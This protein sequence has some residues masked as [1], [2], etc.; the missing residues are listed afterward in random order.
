M[1]NRGLR[2]RSRVPTRLAVGMLLSV[3]VAVGVALVTGVVPPP[4]PAAI[5]P[6]PSQPTAPPSSPRTF[7][8]RRNRQHSGPQLVESYG[9]IPLHF[10]RNEG[11]TDERVA[12]LARGAA[13]TLFLTHAGEAV[14]ALRKGEPAPAVHRSLRHEGR[15]VVSEVPA[16]TTSVLRIKLEGADLRTSAQGRDDLPGKSNY[17]IGSDPRRWR[18]D[19]P[20]FARVHYDHVYP[21]IDLT[22]YGNQRQ[23]EYDWIVSPGADP[24]A[25]GMTFEGALNLSIDAGG[26]LVLALPGGEVVNKPPVVYQDVQGRRVPVPGR[27]VRRGEREIGFDVGAYDRSRPL[28]IDPV[29]VYSTYLG[30]SQTDFGAAIAVG[31]DGSTYLGGLTRS[32]DFPPGT[33]YQPA[34]AGGEDAFL[35]KLNPSGSA[36]VYSTYLGGSGDD[37]AW[38]IAVDAAG[39]AYVSGQTRSTNFPTS[40]PIQPAHAGGLDAFVAKVSASGSVLLYST[41]LG[42]SVDDFGNGIAVDGS[43]SAFVAGSTKSLNFPVASAYQSTILGGNAAFVAKL[44]PSGTT[45]DYSTYLGGVTLAGNGGAEVRSIAVDN[46]GNAYLTGSAFGTLPIAN[47]Y[48]STCSGACAFVTKLGPSGL[49]LD[50]STYLSAQSTGHGIA[51]DGT[52]SAYVTGTTSSQT[53]P[54]VNALQS[55]YA[56]GPFDAFVTR[57]NPIGSTLVYSTYLGGSGDDQAYSVAVDGAGNAYVTGGTLSADFPTVNAYQGYGGSYDVIVTKLSAQGSMIY[58]TYLGGAGGDSGQAIALDLSGSAYV[59]GNASGGFPMVDAYQASFSGGSYDGFVAKLQDRPRLSVADVAETEGTSGIVSATFSVTLSAAPPQQVQVAYETA[60]GTAVAGSDYVATSGVL[61]FSVGVSTQTL[62]VSVLGDTLLEGD[63]FFTLNLSDPVNADIES[64]TATGVVIG[65]DEPLPSIAI[66]DA[67]L[68]EGD[69]GSTSALV[70]LSLSTVRGVPVTAT[71]STA[72]GTAGAESDYDSTSGTVTFAP[73]TTTATILVPVRGDTEREARETFLV[74]LSNSNAYATIDDSTAVVTINDDDSPLATT[75]SLIANR[76]QHTATLLPNGNV[77]V[78]GGG[79]A[80]RFDRSG[81]WSA[82]TAP[83]LYR[84]RHTA[85]MMPSGKALITGGWWFQALGTVQVYDPATGAW[86]NTQSLAAPRADHTTTLLADG[87]VLAVGGTQ[88]AGAVG[89]AEVYDHGS[90]SWSPAGSLITARS[91]HTATLLGDGRVV[92][93]GGFGSSGALGSVE[94]YD[95]TWSAGPSLTTERSGH[96]AVLLGNGKVLVVGGDGASGPLASAQ[97][98]DPVAGTW[99][100]TGPLASPRRGLS[101]ALLNTGEVL[102]AGGTTTGGGAVLD[103]ELYDPDNG[104]WSRAGRLAIQRVSATATVLPTGRVLLVG[105]NPT[106]GHT[107]ELF[108]P[109]TSGWESAGDLGA[110]RSNHTATLLPDGNVLAVGRASGAERFDPGNSNWSA[111]SPPASTRRAHTATLLPSG[112]VLIAGGS[113]SGPPVASSELYQPTTNSW[114][115]TG[116]LVLS[117]SSHT[118][119]LLADG[120]VLAAGGHAFAEAPMASAEL[121]SG[122]TWVQTGSMSVPRF[123]HTATLLRSGRVLVVGG[124][125]GG[126]SLRSAELFDPDTGA[127]MAAAPPNAPRHGHVAALLADGRVLVAGGLAAAGKVEIY[128]P[129]ANSWTSL[130]DQAIAR[131]GATATVLWSGQ[132]AVAGGFDGSTWPARVD[133]FD[134]GTA[135]WVTAALAGSGRRW[136]TATLLPNGQILIA[137]GEVNGGY[138]TSSA[139]FDPGPRGSRVKPAITSMPAYLAYDALA[140]EIAGTDL[141]GDSEAVSGGTSSSSVKYPLIELRSLENGRQSTVPWDSRVTL[142]DE[143]MTLSS[144]VLPEGLDAGPHLVRVVSAGMPSTAR[145]VGV[146]CSVEIVQPPASATVA[147]GQPALFQVSAEG[148][149]RYQWQKNGTSI[150]GAT[151]SSYATPPVSAADAGSTYRVLVSGNCATAI[152]APATLFVTD[153]SGPT[154]AVHS[155]TAG[156]RLPVESQ[157]QVLWTATDNVRVCKATA[158]LEYSNNGG[159]AWSPAPPGG[160]LPFTVDHTSS[161]LAPG[162]GPA[163]SQISYTV[164]TAFPSGHAGSL[165]RVRVQA[166]DLNGNPSDVAASGTFYIVK[167]DPEAQTL[168]LWNRARMQ[169]QVGSSVPELDDLALQL[170]NLADHERVRGVVEDVGSLGPLTSLYAKWDAAHA[171]DTADQ[172]DWANTILFGC[173]RASASES[174]PSWCTPDVQDIEGLQ[175]LVTARKRTLYANLKYVIVVGDDRIIPF[176]RLQDQTSGNASE[177]R[178]VAGG[179]P[180]LTTATTVGRALGANR[181]LSDDPLLTD[182]V[183]RPD[184]VSGLF[185]P[186]FSGGRLVENADEIIKTISTFMGQDGVMDLTA[187]PEGHRVLVTGYDFMLAGASGIRSSWESVPGVG[188]VGQNLLGESWGETLLRQGLQGDG[189]GRYGVMSLNG[190]ATHFLEGVPAAGAVFGLNA[191]DMYGAD[192]CSTTSGNPLNANFDGAVVYSMGCHGGLVVP[193]SC[194]TTNDHTLDLPQTFL[195]RGAAVYL[196]NTGYGYGD[197]GVVAYSMLLSDLFTQ[198]LVGEQSIAVGDAVRMTKS[199]SYLRDRGGI[200]DPTRPGRISGLDAYD[201]KVLMQWTLF[202]MPM[203]ELRLRTGTDPGDAGMGSSKAR[204]RGSSTERIGKVSVNRRVDRGPDAVVE[205][206]LATPGPAVAGGPPQYVTRLSLL[207]DLS[208]TDV[209]TKWHGGEKL[210]TL[211]TPCPEESDPRRQGC[212]Y[213]L[214]NKMST[215]SGMPVQPLMV[216]D[217][218]LSGTSQHG[219]VWMGGTYV[220]EANWT[221]V[222]GGVVTNGFDNSEPLPAPRYVMGE[223]IAT[224]T[225][226]SQGGCRA[227]DDEVNS[228]AITTGE[229]LKDSNHEF[230]I[231]RRYV[232]FD[233]EVLYYNNTNPA[234]AS[235]NCLRTGPALTEG[236]GLFTG[237][238]YHNVTGQTVEWAV[239][240]LP[241]DVWRVVVVYNDEANSVWEPLELVKD[242]GGVWRGSKT[243]T[244]ATRV[245]YL[246]QAVDNRGNVGR[247]LFRDTLP[248]SG[249]ERQFP[250]VVDAALNASPPTPTLSITDVSMAEGNAGTTNAVFTVSLSAASAEIVTVSAVTSDLSANAGSDYTA[251][252]PTT[253]TFA[254]GVT[255]QTFTVPVLGDTTAESTET[256]QVTLSGPMNATIID[257]VGVGTITNDDTAPPARTFVSVLG[258][259]ANVCS[260]QTTPCRN[261]AAA[262]AQVATDGDVIVLNSGDYADAPITIGKGVKV[263]SPS[264]TVA[265]VRQPISVNASSGRVVL[266]GLTI[267][268]LGAGDGVT[269]VAANALSIEDTTIDLWAAGLRL[270]NVAASHVTIVNT[271]FRAS[272]TGITDSGGAV[273]NRVSVEETRF[274]GNTKGIEV[275]AGSFIIRESTFV[276]NSG[277]GVIVGPGS[278]D[279][280]RSE[281]SLNGTGVGALVGGTARI[282]RSR[283]FGNATGLSAAAGG[284][285]TT[286]GR[287]LIRRNGVNVFGAVLTAPEQ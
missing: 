194:S 46:A 56:G 77:L 122:A 115:T 192:R 134:P 69:S 159:A 146:A 256:F 238:A 190:H 24:G 121:Y 54:V 277:N 150:A 203:Y 140:L 67:V 102:V 151:Q 207:F 127:W 2:V 246:L 21:G 209:Y 258:N 253:I 225:G 223:P 38:G 230:T 213:R 175:D 160:G 262:I 167:P 241:A 162:L 7:A 136:H 83:G 276:G 263:S 66:G 125:D 139:L 255:T 109:M 141:R 101:C 184:D 13:Y 108:D 180:D 30:G 252:G 274:E 41:F 261:L 35:A 132:V 110:A 82:V 171:G 148:A 166:W 152:S 131:E 236:G 32:I 18:T 188:P 221:P 218:R 74:N 284:T 72:D 128:D 143:P 199:D 251:T 181:F 26:S 254:P 59:T 48:R 16:G 211:T 47:A 129:D 96:C 183:I 62:T 95:G 178:Y 208:A 103:T 234:Q 34:N 219:V 130:P 51:V 9:Q 37:N 259:D 86:G 113:V 245:G 215:G 214:N 264:G 116:S 8:T 273:G 15:E 61:T 12:F 94:I 90:E 126:Q 85:L 97:V 174:Y 99:A 53:F 176:A 73:W 270:N 111:A 19:V 64:G 71:F 287:N 4:H 269:L 233:A 114:S 84:S 133:I 124:T 205:P 232:S 39:S 275:T 57:L 149:R 100:A 197:W 40:N 227:S 224:Q 154:V 168:I 169:S 14:L 257:G 177:E 17:F 70:P 237:G 271:V 217:S 283:V 89:A 6:L 157:Q 79:T 52:G 281:L 22:Y 105:G 36:L 107:A 200:S 187:E 282:S 91:L 229:L 191:L 249:I 278:I 173:D 242:G 266:R 3:F 45:L 58:S 123:E 81:A 98:F 5:G 135:K 142:S 78:V 170:A 179:S 117:R 196:G 164:P 156:D 137:G 198:R 25:I 55:S 106:L 267:K 147:L 88:S 240:G 42:G 216:Y 161:C 202:G 193:G 212:Y 144:L 158:S 201:R 279:V 285:V 195:A 210:A 189:S 185:R 244:G 172:H 50:Y 119:T 60:D 265:F 145:V 204:T 235:Q 65:D 29:L 92:V 76:Q 272:G 120:R 31:A 228:M 80:E 206:A 243:F 222:I 104:T 75:A 155:P 44:S 163:E 231:Q 280:Q 247:L 20:Q 260:D 248:N 182:A 43:G 11:Q 27:Y 220:E 138:M 165:Y 33:V 153:T 87:R 226:S 63:E 112:S 1:K 239:P 286:T 93:V 28:V 186:D 10:E 68:A 118:A 23:L 49:T 250:L 268:G